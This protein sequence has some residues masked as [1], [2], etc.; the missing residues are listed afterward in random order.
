MGALPRHAALHSRALSD[1]SFALL[2]A[3]LPALLERSGVIID[4]NFRSGEHEASLAPLCEARPVLQVLCRTPEHL[5]T[6]RVQA[7]AG[8]SSRDPHDALPPQ[9]S[10]SAAADRFLALPGARI[11]LAGDAPLDDSLARIRSA[12]GA[13]GICV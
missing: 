10:Y 9:L 6:A 3:L 2:F 11:Q 12:A 4:G 1:A 7:R 13:G 8:T 5:R